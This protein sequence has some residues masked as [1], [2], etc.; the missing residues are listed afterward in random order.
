LRRGA[1]VRSMSEPAAPALGSLA[2]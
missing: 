1:R 2:A